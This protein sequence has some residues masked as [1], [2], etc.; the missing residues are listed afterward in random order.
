MRTLAH[1][2]PGQRAVIRHVNAEGSALYQRLLEMGLYEG[3]PDDRVVNPRGAAPRQRRSVRE[4]L[5]LLRG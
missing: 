5:R 1:V 4:R 2:K 3:C